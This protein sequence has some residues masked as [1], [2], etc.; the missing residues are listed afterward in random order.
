MINFKKVRWKNFLSTG[1][2]FTEIE[3]NKDST[4]LIIG[5]NGAGKST[6]LDA[7]CFGL[8]GKPFRGINKPQLLNTVNASACIVEIEFS[9]VVVIAGGVN[10]QLELDVGAGVGVQS[11]TATYFGGS[12]TTVLQFIYEVEESSWADATDLAYSGQG[13]LTLG[14]S[15]TLND[16]VGNSA[17]LTLPVPGAAGSLSATSDIQL[18]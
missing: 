6:I 13:S 8:F 11:A 12:G 9:E 16:S 17:T 14:G 5:E 10:L 3:L 15:T 7:L 1:N 18:N 2:Q 4:T